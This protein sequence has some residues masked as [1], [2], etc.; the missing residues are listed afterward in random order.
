[1][2][3]HPEG[4]PGFGKKAEKAQREIREHTTPPNSRE[5]IGKE[6][7]DRAEGK[8]S[9]GQSPRDEARKDTGRVPD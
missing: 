3:N 2:K 1:M 5:E 8:T 9:A 6:T 7:A 4:N